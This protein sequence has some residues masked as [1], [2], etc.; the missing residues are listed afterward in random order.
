[1]C[2]DDMK[3]NP[4]VCY[5]DGSAG[6]MLNQNDAELVFSTLRISTAFQRKDHEKIRKCNQAFD[7]G[8]VNSWNNDLSI[9]LCK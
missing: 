8:Q 9:F 6:Q 5:A 4:N 2:E 3:K 7:F 1:M